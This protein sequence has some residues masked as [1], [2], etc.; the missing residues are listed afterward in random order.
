[1]KENFEGRFQHGKT[2]FQHFSKFNNGILKDEDTV[3]AVMDTSKN[4]SFSILV[5]NISANGIII[6]VLQTNDEYADLNK[7]VNI[8]KDYVIA[9]NDI[10]SFVL[11]PVSNITIVKLKNQTAGLNASY[12]GF[13]RILPMAS[14]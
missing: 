10:K 9:A 8:V 3:V 7:S 2:E 13:F 12:K 6:N 5:E 11:T 1:M 14:L 4:G